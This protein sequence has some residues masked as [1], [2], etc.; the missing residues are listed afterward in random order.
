MKKTAIFSAALLA[1]FIVTGAGTAAAADPDKTELVFSKSQGPYSELFISGVKPLLE[2]L[3]Y[4]IKS[5]DLS[6]L[7]QADLA[8]NDREVDFNVEQHTAYMNHFNRTQGGHLTALTEVPTVL[9]GIYPGAKNDLAELEDG[10]HIA[11]PNDASN[12]ARALA[13]LQKA[14]L[15]KVKADTD[16][17]VI[18]VNDIEEN[19]RK[20][21]L[22][23]MNSLNIPAVATDFDYIVITGSVVYNAKIDP[24]TALLNEDIQPYLMLQLVVRE[25]DQDKLWAEDL[26]QAYRSAEFKE[27]LDKNNDGL[28][29]YPQAGVPLEK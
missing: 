16:P 25:E 24:K 7:F 9:A 14:G 26:A 15:I 20:L 21:K 5:V 11:I 23:E 8:L 6:D 1:V 27:Y 13:I 17:A 12:T 3:G 29:Y 19:P 10:D 28:W 22:T 2:K 18:T 4:T